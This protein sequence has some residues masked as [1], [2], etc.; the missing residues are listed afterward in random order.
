MVQP[1]IQLVITQSQ[2][3]DGTSETQLMTNLSTTEGV[4]TVITGLL[5]NALRLAITQDVQATKPPSDL[6]LPMGFIT[7]TL[8]ER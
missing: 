6:V 7:P 3:P 5:L 2:R 4:W 1:P 8:R